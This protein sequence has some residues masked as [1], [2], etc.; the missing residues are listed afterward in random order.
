MILDPKDF[1]HIL[2]L[3]LTL[4]TTVSKEGVPNA[5]PYGCVMPV[6]RPLDLIA[7]ASALPRDTLHNIRET[8]EFVVNV[9]SPQC[10]RKAMLCAKAYPPEVNELEAVGLESFP[11][12]EVAPLRVKDALGWIEARLEEE[13]SRNN[14]ALIIGKVV[15]AEINDA[16]LQNGKLNESPVVIMFPFFK[17]LGA[18]V[19][20]REDFEETVGT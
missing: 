15:C 14:Y 16:Y 20:S 7:I 10:F 5:A 17:T 12:R 3:P 18:S 9:V 2:P 8:R 13:I 1:K 6:L 19:G 4:I 11:S